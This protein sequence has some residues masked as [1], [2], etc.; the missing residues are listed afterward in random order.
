M[1]AQVAIRVSLPISIVVGPQERRQAM[2]PIDITPTS[3]TA[4]VAVS[5][6]P[7][8]FK[9]NTRPTDANPSGSLVFTAS[10][11]TPAGTYTPTVMVN[12]PGKPRRRTSLW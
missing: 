7:A 9:R 2:V 11:A 3:E 6:L 10:I 5:G 4:Q 8:A 1:I 12:S